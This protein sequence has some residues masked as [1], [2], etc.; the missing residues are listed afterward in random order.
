MAAW[1]RTGIVPAGCTAFVRTP[2][3]TLTLHN[4]SGA[5]ITL[6]LRS[7][8]SG[9]SCSSKGPLPTSVASQ[10]HRSQDVATTTPSR[11]ATLKFKPLKQCLHQRIL[12][13]GETYKG[14]KNFYCS[15][16]NPG[17]SAYASYHLEF[18]VSEGTVYWTYDTCTHNF[19]CGH[20]DVADS[21]YCYYQSGCDFSSS[22]T[23]PK[24]SVAGYTQI[25]WAKLYA[26]TFAAFTG[27]SCI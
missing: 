13:M 1:V 4:S 12:P 14:T 7:H 9:L 20:T 19:G 24:I 26:D 8:L 18:G 22:F 5:S 16:G 11:A 10:V 15:T 3:N 25:L 23:P 17:Q 21:R 6:T 27:G 2:T